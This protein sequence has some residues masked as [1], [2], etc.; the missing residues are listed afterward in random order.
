MRKGARKLINYDIIL[1][2]YGSAP[3]LRNS[4]ASPPAHLP[5][6]PGRDWSEDQP[7]KRARRDGGGRGGEEEKTSD[8]VIRERLRRERPCRTL[9][10]RNV[11]VG[12]KKEVPIRHNGLERN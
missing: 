3:P 8:E 4:L 11:E 6:P 12:L 7:A 2:A 1:S 9:F 10:V 5:R